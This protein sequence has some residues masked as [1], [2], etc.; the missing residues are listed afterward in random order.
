MTTHTPTDEQERA[1]AQVN[2]FLIDS[3][4]K[5]FTLTGAA[6]TG[7]ST[8]LQ[9]LSDLGREAMI[10]APTNKATNVLRSKGFKKATTLDRVL[11]KSVYVPV[12]RDP[13]AEE[14]SFC[15]RHN[16]E[17]PRVV[18]EDTYAKIDNSAEGLVVICDESSMT[19]GDESARLINLYSKVIFVGDNFQLTPIDGEAWFQTIEPDV[20][21]KEIV[22]TAALSEITQIVNLIR[23]R[24]PEWKKTAWRKEVSL[25]HQNDF[26]AVEVALKAADIVIAHKNMGII[27]LTPSA[28]SAIFL[29]INKG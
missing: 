29:D 2:D 22:R 16:I 12:E 21:L 9:F 11:N 5:S 17:V 28:Y 18:T 13:T 19:N 24:S 10:C 26:D 8:M 23:R 20:T 4:R 3:D 1:I 15:E 14:I 7:K 6:G 27:Y 25:I